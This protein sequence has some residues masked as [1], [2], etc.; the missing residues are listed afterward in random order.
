MGTQVDVLDT[1]KNSLASA[2]IDATSRTILLPN[3]R[4]GTWTYDFRPLLLNNES[5]DLACRS[6]WDALPKN[7]PFQ[8]GGL[9][10]AAIVLVAG[11][12]AKARE[13]GIHTN[14]FYIRKSRRKDGLQNQIEGILTDKNIVLVDDALNSGRSFMRQIKA[15]EEAGK[16]VHTIA[17]LI[18]YRDLS[19][20]KEFT[21]RGIKIVSI[22][23]LK[24]L[25]G[26]HDAKPHGTQHPSPLPRDPFNIEWKFESLNPSYFNVLPKSAPAI[27]DARLY[28]GA[29]NGTLWALNQSDGT[30][31]WSFK[32]LYGAGAKRIFSSPA[33]SKGIVYFGA[34]DG[35]F[36]ALDSSTGN[37]KWVF[38]DADWVGSSP[39]VAKD[40]GAVFVGLEFGLWNKAGALVALD[41]NTGEKR[42]QYT[43]ET[44]VH[45]SPAY[46]KKFGLVV[47]GS[48]EGKVYACNAGTGSLLWTYS[49]GGPVRAS[50]AFDEERGYVCFGSEDRNI[51]VLD[52]RTGKKVYSI[53][54][55]EPIYSSPIVAQGHLYFGLLDKRMMCIDLKNGNVLWTTWAHSRIFSSPIIIDG[56]IFFGSNDGRL[57]EVDANT[58][59]EISYMQLTERIVNKIAYN[60][61]SKQFFVPTYAN[62]IYCLSRKTV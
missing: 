53:E 57:Y 27:D 11:L 49:T 37:K 40:L 16:K 55:L 30:V 61:H 39:C 23:T 29:D 5:L 2:R 18:R 46:S 3:G 32:T 59:Q 13:H 20:Y 38:M 42:W 52:V 44:M 9:E 56:N 26:E 24:D 28:F 4:I 17:V 43:T 47:V 21:D 10:T 14:G 6:L 7:P 31:A 22:F 48:T 54:I 45:S 8:I 58:G 36:Y 60:P 25:P 34:Y 51:Y 19:F 15:I 41:T 33:V 1:L 50:F 12:L 62:Q 35:N